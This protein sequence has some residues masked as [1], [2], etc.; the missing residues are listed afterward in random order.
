MS[1]HYTAK[2]PSPVSS[3]PRRR[4]VP[5]AMTMRVRARTCVYPSN[6][7]DNL[8]FSLVSARRSGKKKICAAWLGMRIFDGGPRRPSI[9]RGCHRP[10]HGKAEKFLCTIKGDRERPTGRRGRVWRRGQG[11]PAQLLAWRNEMRVDLKGDPP[12]SGGDNKR[13]G[14]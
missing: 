9:Y 7:A 14:V 8:S 5:M 12:R 11:C 3:S 4:H 10:C 13:G 6:R 2:I 1:P